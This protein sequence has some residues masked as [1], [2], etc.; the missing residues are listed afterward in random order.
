MLKNTGLILLIAGC[1]STALLRAEAA[2]ARKQ[3]SNHVFEASHAPFTSRTGD[4]EAGDAAVDRLNEAQLNSSYRGPV[5]IPGQ[6]IPQAQPV[7]DRQDDPTKSDAAGDAEVDLLNDAQIGQAYK[8]PVYYVGHP[9]PQAQPVKIGSNVPVV[10]PEKTPL[11]HD[12]SG[13]GRVDL[14]NASQIDGSYKGPV[15]H[16]GQPVPPAKP[17]DV[18]AVPASGERGAGTVSIAP[19]SG[20][21]SVLVVAPLAA[22]VPSQVQPPIPAFAPARAPVGASDSPVAAPVASSGSSIR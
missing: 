9:A 17:V 6:P 7:R 20:S 5:Y 19:L 18:V 8:G 12:V 15:Y 11:A 10:P 1:A 21:Q 13:D 3:T 4:T 22:P 14:L 2:P 16:P